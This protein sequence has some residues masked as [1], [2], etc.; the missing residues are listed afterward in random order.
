MPPMFHVTSTIYR[1]FQS[2]TSNTIHIEQIHPVLLI[3]EILQNVFYFVHE[4]SESAG[5]LCK[6]V[7]VCKRWADCA[8][9]LLWRKPPSLRPI[10]NLLGEMEEQEPITVGEE[11]RKLLLLIIIAVLVTREFH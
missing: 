8:L 4:G 10:V 3:D 6:C 2:E 5:G 7:Y 9:P 1:M 11:V